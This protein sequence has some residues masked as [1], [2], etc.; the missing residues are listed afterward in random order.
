MPGI[1]DDL[2]FG[3]R[4]AGKA[5][6]LIKEAPATV[7]TAPKIYTPQGEFAGGQ[8]LPESNRQWLS[9]FKDRSD[10]E[11]RAKFAKEADKPGWDKLADYY[12]ADSADKK[13]YY[14]AIYNQENI[15]AIHR[16]REAR[17]S[18]GN[19]VRSGRNLAGVNE[20]IAKYIVDEAR[21]GGV[22]PWDALALGLR[23]S[24]LGNA[25]GRQN[26]DGSITPI[27]LFSY[28]AGINNPVTT[29]EDKFNAY[30]KAVDF[31]KENGAFKDDRQRQA[32]SDYWDSYRH[33]ASAVKPY[34]GD[35][36]VRDAVKY[37]QAGRYNP[38]DGDYINKVR[39]DADW[40]KNNKA[41]MDWY[42]S[43]TGQ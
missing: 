20:G 1:L 29:G 34:A 11:A 37:F 5:M 4:N 17:R 36:V 23:E 28:W 19:I 21:R 24:S 33:D 9:Q 32:I 27:N 39:K 41:F 43:Y 7:R 6:G 8:N 22:D 31:F 16:M 2:K 13:L 15:D 40:L 18:G 38:N 30:N 12:W 10:Y 3:L 25:K 35:N 42:N 26:D 14:D